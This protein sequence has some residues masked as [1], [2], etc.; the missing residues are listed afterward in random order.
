MKKFKTTYLI[1]IVLL[2]VIAC[3]GTL[4]APF[5]SQ[6]TAQSGVKAV[7][8]LDKYSVLLVGEDYVDLVKYGKQRTRL[9]EATAPISWFKIFEKKIALF[10][11]DG[12]FL[13]LDSTTGQVVFK[14]VLSMFSGACI[15]NDLVVYSNVSHL[16]AVRE[17]GE[18][19]WVSTKKFFGNNELEIWDSSD[20]G[21]VIR[22]SNGTFIF[23][24]FAGKTHWK[25][26]LS[27]TVGFLWL[28]RTIPL[29][30]I[31]LVVVGETMIVVWDNVT[32]VSGGKVVFSERVGMCVSMCLSE[33]SLYI[34]TIDRKLVAFSLKKPGRLYELTAPTYVVRVCV[35]EDLLA[36]QG[37][38]NN[39]YLL[40]ASNGSPYAMISFESPIAAFDFKY[41]IITA[42]LFSGELI[43]KKIDEIHPRVFAEKTEEWT[44]IGEYAVF[45]I[46]LLEESRELSVQVEKISAEV[47]VSN[48]TILIKVPAGSSVKS[49][50]V[51]AKISSSKGEVKVSLRVY[52]TKSNRNFYYWVVVVALI[53]LLIVLIPTKLIKGS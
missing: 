27:R 4:G 36:L 24:D 39:I 15:H 49:F 40:S 25:Y 31:D 5:S 7:K 41:N 34:I 46:T 32:I 26:S 14:R 6:E 20:K 10:Q 35:Y 22:L 38:D 18:L 16:L 21:L 52:V 53:A 23:I 42:V 45:K 33:D 2:V 13:V 28:T 47:K 11:K 8:I 3:V 19:E 29:P 30:V 9:Y 48:S 17:S 1:F 37:S 50:N 12:R 44:R 43:T 51:V